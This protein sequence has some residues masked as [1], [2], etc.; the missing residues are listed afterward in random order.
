MFHSAMTPG[1]SRLAKLSCLRPESARAIL[2]AERF[3][4]QS[5]Q[6]LDC[7]ITIEFDTALGGKNTAYNQ[8]KKL[9]ENTRRA[10]NYKCKQ[11]LASGPF[12]AIAVWENPDGGS[13]HVH[14]LVRWSPLDR[15]DLDNRIRRAL[16]KIAPKMPDRCV[17]VKE[18]YN[19][20]TLA[21]YMVKGIDAPFA[22]HFH[23]GHVPQG[24]ID[25][26]RITISRSLGPAA[27]KLY[28]KE[29]GLDPLGR[30][31]PKAGAPRP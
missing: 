6:K 4:R 15:D 7:L 2:H 12:D 5:R 22:Q 31:L 9:W 28:A 17:N 23:I 1:V 30:P 19:P 8:F 16:K 14:W 13:L 3:A 25:H 21:N 27:R 20:R 26:R 11:G 10:W 24:T 18:A 29:T